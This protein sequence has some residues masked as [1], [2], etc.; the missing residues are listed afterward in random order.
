MT[1]EDREL[2]RQTVL[3]KRRAVTTFL[4]GAEG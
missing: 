4:T 3:D 2:I 1:A